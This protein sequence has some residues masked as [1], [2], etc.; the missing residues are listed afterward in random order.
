MVTAYFGVRW[1]SSV[2]SDLLR[3]ELLVG[4]SMGLIYGA[5][6]WVSLPLLAWLGRKDLSPFVQ[7]GLLVP[8]VIA[9]LVTAILTVKGGA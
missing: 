4:T 3:S 7:R 6:A 9:V 2:P 5:P 1:W 8:L